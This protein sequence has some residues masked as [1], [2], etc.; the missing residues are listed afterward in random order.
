MAFR[1]TVAWTWGG[2]PGWGGGGT[3]VSPAARKGRAGRGRLGLDGS[4]LKPEAPVPRCEA[5]R[6]TEAQW[7]V[8]SGPQKGWVLSHPGD[9]LGAVNWPQRSSAP[10]PQWGLASLLHLGAGGP[11]VKG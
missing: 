1:D 7:G 10:L 6:G 8:S 4:H 5:D 9:V 3:L 2:G 11:G